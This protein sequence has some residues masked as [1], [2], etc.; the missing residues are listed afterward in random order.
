MIMDLI[1][2]FLIMSLCVQY[3]IIINCLIEGEYITKKTLFKECIP[4]YWV[5]WVYW[6]IFYGIPELCIYL[7]L[8]D[9]IKKYRRLK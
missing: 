8:D 2:W 4:F 1:I 3:Y 5:Y 7:F 9:I 6:L